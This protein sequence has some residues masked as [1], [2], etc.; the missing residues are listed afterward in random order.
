[1][2]VVVCVCV[3]VC[4]VCV[5]VCVCEH[6]AP[7]KHPKVENAVSY[8]LTVDDD[9]PVLVEVSLD[10][11]HFLIHPQLRLPSCCPLHERRGSEASVT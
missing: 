4:V 5:C 1:M 6:E 7:Q 8:V 11:T 10:H 2:C 9:G 3:C